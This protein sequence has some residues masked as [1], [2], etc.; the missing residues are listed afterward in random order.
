MAFGTKLFCKRFKGF[1]A[2]GCDYYP[3]AGLAS[4]RADARPI[5]LVAPVMNAVFFMSVNLMDEK[6]TLNFLAKIA[7]FAYIC[8]IKIRLI[9]TNGCNV[10]LNH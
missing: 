9:C 3:E 6:S 5:P 10:L 1:L 2:S 7:N 4:L 8:K